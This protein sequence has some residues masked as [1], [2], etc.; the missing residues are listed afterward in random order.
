MFFRVKSAATFNTSKQLL[1]ETNRA[2]EKPPLPKKPSFNQNIH[3]RAFRPAMPIRKGQT[4]C[5]L[6]RFPD[7]KE[8][9]PR[10]KV[11]IKTIETD[12]PADEIP[13][14]KLTHKYKSRPQTT[15]ACNKRNLKTSFP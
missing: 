8:D 6:A 14:F 13:A 2:A 7:Y 9:P 4:R 3:E 5:S 15:I 12:L 11:R 1:E 10:E